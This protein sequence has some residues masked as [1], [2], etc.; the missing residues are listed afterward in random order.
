MQ[1]I[2]AQKESERKEEMLFEKLVTVL[3]FTFYGQ[4]QTGMLFKDLDLN[5]VQRFVILRNYY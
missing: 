5:T 1:N 2:M 3:A 4:V